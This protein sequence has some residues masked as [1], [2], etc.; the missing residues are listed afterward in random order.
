MIGYRLINMPERPQQEIT[1]LACQGCE[2]PLWLRGNG[3]GSVVMRSSHSDIPLPLR[4]AMT[5]ISVLERHQDLRRR[6][7]HVMTRLQS[8]AER[9]PCAVFLGDS[10]SGKTTAANSLLGDGLLPT[11]VISNTRYPTLVRYAEQVRAVAI[12]TTGLRHPLLD[13]VDLP[14]QPISLIE[15]GLPNERLRRLEIL[16]TPGGFDPDALPFLPGL[17]PIR[18]PVWCT[19]ATQ[20]WKES[21]R[22]LWTS[23]DS[24]LA[25]RGL[26]VVTGLDRIEQ[27]GAIPRLLSRLQSEAAPFFGHVACSAK[28]E[29]Q[30]V[31][32]A[33]SD[34]PSLTAFLPELASRLGLRRAHTVSRLRARLSR[35][36]A[37]PAERPSLSFEPR[38]RW[39]EPDVPV[40]RYAP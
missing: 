14:N 21:E 34:W 36:A 17:P 40:T 7:A 3:S 18:I 6:A 37:L 5:E 24:R 39:L 2:N 25:R 4:Q 28:N 11:G 29:G 13:E 10:N 23:L 27:A 12:T 33:S 31:A 35:L 38:P 30:V 26:L 8:A 1:S 16:D 32:L 15:V 19:V 22:R 9:P 20:A